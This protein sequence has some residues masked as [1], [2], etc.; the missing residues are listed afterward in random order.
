M[1]QAPISAEP[2]LRTGRG[3]WT[4][5]RRA[6]VRA[7]TRRGVSLALG[8]CLLPACRTPVGDD[9]A[10]P[11]QVVLDD[12]HLATFSLSYAVASAPLVAGGDGRIDWSGL[13]LDTHGRPV[14]PAQDVSGLVLVRLSDVSVQDT[15]ADLARGA[16][17][18]QTISLQVSCA[19]TTTSCQVSGLGY[20]SGHPIDMAAVFVEGSGPWLA[21]L[22]PV[23][24]NEPMALL[25]LVPTVDGPDTAPLSGQAGVLG[26][27]SLQAAAPVEL[28]AG[29]SLDWSGLTRTSQG[30]ALQPQRLDRVLLARVSESTSD[31]DRVLRLAEAAEETWQGEVDGGMQIGLEDLRDPQGA[32]FGGALTG[33]GDWLLSLSCSTCTAPQPAVLVAV[34]A[35]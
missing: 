25:E 7:G 13:A 5:G 22:D 31:E 1:T 28:G 24:D 23:Q 19:A 17:S 21:W 34:A 27:S 26:L 32:P 29:A 16:L 20:D 33:E 4:A 14:D 35:P 15:L 10:A 30:V 11:A 8:L 12:A 9:T 18:Q 3:A 2:E 6:G